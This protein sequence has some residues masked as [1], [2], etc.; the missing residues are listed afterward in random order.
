[1][2]QLPSQNR[3]HLKSNTYHLKI[4]TETV[5]WFEFTA[6]SQKNNAI[7][8]FESTEEKQDRNAITRKLVNKHGSFFKT[9][10]CGIVV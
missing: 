8:L 5:S 9:R 4:L 6:S 7:F 2:Q 3:V 1:M 10:E